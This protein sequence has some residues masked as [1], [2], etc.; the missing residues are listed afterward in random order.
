MPWPQ[1]GLLGVEGSNRICRMASIDFPDAQ[2][3]TE[4]FQVPSEQK[5]PQKAL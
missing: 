4:Q 5:R 3:S 2:G 1:E